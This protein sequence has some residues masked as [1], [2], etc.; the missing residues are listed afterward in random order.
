[1]FLFGRKVTEY[2]FQDRLTIVK[3]TFDSDVLNIAIK[4]A[5][6][7]FFLKLAGF[8]FREHDENV[9]IF[10]STNASDRCTTRITT[11]CAQYV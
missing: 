8:A 10:F 4:H 7:L 3:T 1:M 6:H 11:S 5:G 2:G 9:D